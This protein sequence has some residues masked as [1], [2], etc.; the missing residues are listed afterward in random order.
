[1]KH[2]LLSGPNLLWVAGDKLLLATNIWEDHGEIQGFAP[3]DTSKKSPWTRK[4][5]VCGSTRSCRTCLCT[6]LLLTTP[7]FWLQGLVC[8]IALAFCLCS[9]RCFPCFCQCIG[10]IWVSPKYNKYR[11][12]LKMSPPGLMMYLVYSLTEAD[13]NPGSY[14]QWDLRWLEAITSPHHFTD[15]FERRIHWK[16]MEN[17]VL[18]R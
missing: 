4:S 2:P 16:T 6:S 17:N 14:G 15:M 13:G 1:M 12:G 18:G 11:R 8:Q 5:Q 7:C 9:C 10:H 3:A